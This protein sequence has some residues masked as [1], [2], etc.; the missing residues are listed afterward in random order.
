MDYSVTEETLA[1]RVTETHDGV[2]PSWLASARG[3]TCGSEF[4]A[5]DAVAALIE[6]LL[7]TGVLTED[8]VADVAVG[9]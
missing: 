1:V 6:L 7:K 5:D 9:G 8:E 4:S 2:A 3:V